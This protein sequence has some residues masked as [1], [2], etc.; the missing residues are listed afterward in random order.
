MRG[1]GSQLQL[2]PLLWCE[3]VFLSEHKIHCSVGEQVVVMLKVADVCYHQSV[4][5]DMW[6]RLA[7]AC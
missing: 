2:L 6:V 1:P 5:D 3:A 4:V 7:F